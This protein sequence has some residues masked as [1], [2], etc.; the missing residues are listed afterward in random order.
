M[1]SYTEEQIASIKKVES[2][3]ADRLAKT[4]PPMTADEK[5]RVLEKYR[6]DGGDNAFGILKVG[7]NAG[8]RVPMEL[9]ALLQGTPYITGRDVNLSNPD[10]DVD[11]LVIGFGG[12]GA[13]AAITAK[14][15]GANVT[16]VTKLRAG[17]SN[18]VMA[19]GGIQCADG[20]DDSPVRYYLDTF[21]GGGYAARPELLKKL[22]TG[23]AKAVKW[24]TE[25]GVTFDADF[26][27]NPIRTSGGGASRRRMRACK[28][29]TGREIM[30]TLRDEVI[31]VGVKIR[32]FSSAVEIVKDEYGSAAG[33]VLVNTV[34]GEI[35]VIR[36]KTVIVATGGAGRLHY[37]GFPTTNH[38]GA[39]ADG[40]VI[41]YRAGVKLVDAD[42]LQYHPTG[43]ALPNSLSGSLV[44]EKVR[45]L[46]A[47]LLNRNGDEFVNSLETRDAVSACILRECACGN[48]IKTDDGYAVWLD[49]PMIDILHGDGT[50]EK[51]LPSTFKT[52]TKCGIDIRKEPIAVYPTLHYQNGGIEIDVNCET[53]VKNLFAAGE[54]TG[55]IHG[56]NRLM[57][58]SLAEI[59]VFGKTAGKVAAER[60]KNARVGKLTLAHV[61]GYETEIERSGVK[62][63]KISPE[64]LPDYTR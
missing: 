62:S 64:I 17:D 9:C 48:G 14:N 7:K 19:E 57:G 56:R 50:I 55:G 43:A 40:L 15:L 28:D 11:V 45:S 60:A 21:G 37:N 36:A 22:A 26:D 46:G 27:G 5:R 23:G 51:S 44:T 53:A 61:R 47:E 32:E 20:S 25:L 12:A 31:N 59:I 38:Y 34:T 18:T 35:S 13:A 49:T 8:E 54:V 1:Y 58:N 16:I 63:D 4:F 10:D 33:A 3:R 29:M 42:S 30:R 52:Y 39:T 2:T 24:L 41:A 6:P